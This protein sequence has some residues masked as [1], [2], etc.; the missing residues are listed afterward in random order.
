MFDTIWDIL[1]AVIYLLAFPVYHIGYAI[2]WSRMRPGLT[3]L[4]HVDA[5][6][7]SF[8][9]RV[10]RTDQWLP[11]VHMLRNLLMVNSLLA[12]SSL[13]LAGVIGNNLLGESYS[14]KL[15]EPLSG[16]GTAYKLI[17]VV[18]LCVIA[19]LYFLASL[20][21]LAHL[22][23]VLGA[24]EGVIRRMEGED[25]T[26]YLGRLLAKASSR[27]TW[28]VRCLFFCLPL[29]LWLIHGI[30]FFLSSLILMLKL[31]GWTD[32]VWGKQPAS[33]PLKPPGNEEAAEE[34]HS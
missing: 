28:G 30:L 8:L 12:S 6:R 9:R 23:L 14:L 31:V 26:S 34:K 3:R 33:E 2:Y 32:F 19:F 24:E 10:R 11:A 13:V 29:L 5:Y 17:F 27:H 25:P 18:C 1:G 15:H 4:S 16:Q 7:R 21:Y 22:N 20:R